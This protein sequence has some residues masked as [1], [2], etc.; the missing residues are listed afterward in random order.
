MKAVLMHSVGGP[1]VLKYQ[2]V[3]EPKIKS[4][5]D[6][7]IRIKA[8]GINP[9][10]TKL[11]SH[12]T[13]YPDRLPTVLGC[14]GAGVIEDI[15]SAVSKF[16]TGDEVYY[17]YGGIGFHPGNY[18]EY[19]ATDEK[20]VAHKPK[21]LD[22]NQAA[23]APLALITA[24][25]SLYNR[26]AIDMGQTA[27]IHAGAGGVGHIAIQLAKIAGAKVATTVSTTSKAQFVRELGA[28]LPIHYRRVN[29]V[30]SILEWTNNEGVDVALDTVGDDTFVKTL[31]AVKIYGDIVTLL[32][33]PPDCDWK[34]ARIRNLRV[35]FELMLT[36]MYRGLAKAQQKQAEILYK[37]A[38]LFDQ[39][40]LKIHIDK[41]FA[42]KDAAEAHK[43]IMRGEGRGKIVLAMD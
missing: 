28:D 9:I 5:T 6:V 24:W 38:E 3:S 17:C 2:D 14:D 35:S 7:L 29:F 43:M 10:D 4:P 13:Y 25:E 11:R 19:N 20:F 8:A 41:V 30:E 16:K 42:L 33:P 15:G 39:N 22:F 27:L 31:S 36:P 37:C 1:E 21:S 40:R 23:A 12:G 34:T 18:A 32:Q 26:A